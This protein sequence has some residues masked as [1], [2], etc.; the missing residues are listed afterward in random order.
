[1]A[2]G[3]FEYND[4]VY[5]SERLSGA[6]QI[7]NK[8][9]GSFEGY[10]RDKNGKV[11]LLGKL[12]KIVVDKT[13]KKL[14]IGNSVEKV[15][16]VY[17]LETGGHLYYIGTAKTYVGAFAS[18]SGMGI[19]K[20]GN[21]VVSDGVMHSVQVFSKDDGR[22]LYHI[23]YDNFQYNPSD[24]KPVSFV[25]YPGI[26]ETD[27]MGRLWIYAG[28]LKGFQVIEYTGAKPEEFSP[29]GK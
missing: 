21:L 17:S 3:I 2:N 26:I 10:F 6:L 1:M 4:K 14:Y 28:G 22:Y 29:K 20:N 5:V 19:D 9:D 23:V 11:A 15:V 24:P 8:T 16:L 18:I 7:Y 12:S 27:K 13:S 25:L